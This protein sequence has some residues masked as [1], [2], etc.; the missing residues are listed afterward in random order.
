MKIS[1]QIREAAKDDR[2][3]V[4]TKVMKDWR[5]RLTKISSEVSNYKRK[6]AALG[7]VEKS[8]DAARK[9]LFDLE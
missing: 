1:D 3:A 7:D 2:D 9:R 8:I 4:P 5:A 6:F